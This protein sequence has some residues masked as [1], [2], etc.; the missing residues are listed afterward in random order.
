LG[1]ALALRIMA[2]GKV[3]GTLNRDNPVAG[4]VGPMHA[5]PRDVDAKVVLVCTTTREGINAALV[6]KRL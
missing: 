1:A 5:E 2:E 3:P 4:Y 6:L